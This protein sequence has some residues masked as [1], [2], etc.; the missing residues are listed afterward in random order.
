MR[1]KF[2]ALKR[3]KLNNDGI[4]L[5]E[6]MAVLAIIAIMVGVGMT[7]WAVVKNA[8]VSKAGRNI[9]TAYDKLKTYTMSKNGEWRMEIYKNDKGMYYAGVYCRDAVTGLDV[10]DG[11]VVELGKY[12]DIYFKDENESS[13]IY[14]D[15]S[16]PLKIYLKPS[17]G[18]V[19]KIKLG[20]IVK[21]DSAGE[22]ESSYGNIEITY[23]NLTNKN[24]KIYYVTGKVVD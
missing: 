3:L 1:N 22:Y 12:I 10:A 5:V 17:T 19:N 8:D 9:M 13:D 6:I 15:E 14:I 16:T 18:G 20:D 11:D 7:S 4:T 21:Y 2:N 24:V 23:N